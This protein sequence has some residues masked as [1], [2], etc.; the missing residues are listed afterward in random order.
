MGGGSRPP[1]SARVLR[2]T[3][4]KTRPVGRLD[5]PGVGVGG[6]LHGAVAG[7]GLSHHAH[8]PSLDREGETGLSPLPVAP[9]VNRRPQGGR[10]RLRLP[11]QPGD[12]DRLRYCI[13]L[14]WH[15]HAARSL[16]LPSRVREGGQ[17]PNIHRT[18]VECPGAYHPVST[19][20]PHRVWLPGIDRDHLLRL[21][22]FLAGTT[23]GSAAQ[24]PGEPRAGQ[25]VHARAGVRGVHCCGSGIA[26]YQSPAPRCNYQIVSI[27]PA[28]GGWEG[29][30]GAVGICVECADPRH[31]LPSTG[32]ALVGG[33]GLHRDL[34]RVCPDSCSNP[35]RS[36]HPSRMAV[37]LR[38]AEDDGDLHP[39]NG[40][41]Q[42]GR[43]RRDPHR[44]RDARLHA[45][46]QHRFLCRIPGGESADG[47]FCRREASAHLS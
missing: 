19:S 2:G 3:P 9:Q 26:L 36:G 6:F 31:L 37:P 33:V 1:R 34:S 43:Q 40:A 39:G 32:N 24:R 45:V 8:A 22:D 5:R 16:P 20:H 13:L 25:S 28:I 18:S 47:P 42:S 15:S 44:A 14:R 17:F 46:L 23:N 11:A 21:G 12:V 7:D 29:P 27:P 4:R 35:R 30:L 41:T 38:N 10:R